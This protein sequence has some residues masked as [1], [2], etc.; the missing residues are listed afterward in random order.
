MNDEYY[1]VWYLGGAEEM[2]PWRLLTVTNCTDLISELISETEYKT[3]LIER[4]AL[5]EPDFNS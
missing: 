1:I 4:L 2:Y 5:E 3:I